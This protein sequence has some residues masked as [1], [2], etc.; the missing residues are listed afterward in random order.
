MRAYI[1]TFLLVVLA[2]FSACKCKKMMLKANYKIND[3]KSLRIQFSNEF[4]VAAIDIIYPSSQFYWVYGGVQSVKW[5]SNS[6]DPSAFNI[7]LR[8]NNL[9]QLASGSGLALA[10]NVLT[11]LQQTNITLSDNYG[12]E[13]GFFIYFSHPT[14]ASMIYA[15][16]ELFSIKPTAS[17]YTPPPTPTPTP[18]PSTTKSAAGTTTPYKSFVSISNRLVMQ[19]YTV[20]L[21]YGV[22]KQQAA[23][24][25]DEEP[26]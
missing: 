18:E 24:D 3:L 22:L 14:N 5:T 17:V 25:C 26:S 1:F 21:I 15:T 8:N 2:T 9:S 23:S 11:N 4:F 12:Q 20:I 16:S 13:Q 6:S 10:N 19:R 7:Y